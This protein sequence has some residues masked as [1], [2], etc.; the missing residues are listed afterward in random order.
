MKRIIVVVGLALVLGAG[1][2]WVQHVRSAS[3]GAAEAMRTAQVA[4][5]TLTASVSASGTLQP[6]A[7]VE[8]RSRSTGTVVDLRVQEGD[9][10]K[11]GQLLAIIDDHDAQAGFETAQAQLSAAQ[12]NLAQSRRQ[13]E[14]TRA[15]N[16]TKITQAEDAIRTA[17]AK[18]A[19]T[20]AGSRP[21]EIAQQVAALQQA[22]LSASL[23]KQTLDRNRDLFSQGLVARQDIDKAQSDYDTA[24]AQVRAAQARLNELQAG[25]TP[26]DIAV[27]RAQVREAESALATA[28]AARLQEAAS[29]AQ[30]TASEA[31]VRNNEADA[32][33]ALDQLS[34]TKITAPIDGIVAKLSVQIGQSVIGGASSGGT[35]VVTIADT[36]TL[37]ADI[38]VDESD[39]AQVRVGMPVRVTVDAL[40]GRTFTGKVTRVAPQSTVTQNVTQ[41]DVMV[42]IENPD[43][44][45][46]LGMSADAEFIVIERQ[47]VL[48]VPAEAVRGKTTKSVLVVKGAELVPVTVETGATDGRQVEVVRGLEAGQTVYLGQAKSGSSDAS[49]SQQTVNPFMPQPPST[50]RSTSR[51]T[52]PSR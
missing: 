22:Q 45:L 51:S 1:T 52:S 23:A 25:S 32:T 40:P 8:V 46:R 41:F 7:S 35:L 5:G 6:Y 31:T 30:V 19:Q 12:A 36:R 33:K 49:K 4:R 2:W 42:T 50:S 21:E 11:K 10:V 3:Q 26:Q 34:E 9:Q 18:L 39:I 48:L 44:Q 27:I 29:A 15:Q 17:Q 38:Q 43:R 37:Q 13:L 14:A 24:Q 28:R 47:N 20:L 16:S